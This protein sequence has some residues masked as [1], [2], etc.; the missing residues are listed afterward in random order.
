MDSLMKPANTGLG[1]LE[2]YATFKHAQVNFRIYVKDLRHKRKVQKLN[3]T[4]MTLE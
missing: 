2:T 4:K 1:M 3:N